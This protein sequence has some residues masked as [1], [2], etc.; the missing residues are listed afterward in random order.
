[1]VGISNITLHFTHRGRL[2][3]F[4][5]PCLLDVSYKFSSVNFPSESSLL[6]SPSIELTLFWVRLYPQCHLSQR[7]SVHEFLGII[8]LISSATIFTSAHIAILLLSL[9]FF[10]PE[11]ILQLCCYYCFSLALLMSDSHIV[12]PPKRDKH[13]NK[14][15]D[16]SLK[17]VNNLDCNIR[18]TWE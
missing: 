4:H 15:E 2:F 5:E 3:L 17:N 16:N 14:D 10:L 12:Q 18:N 11:L 9:H 8:T 7:T 13:G 6:P 1:M